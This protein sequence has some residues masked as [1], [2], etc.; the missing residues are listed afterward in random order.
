MPLNGSDG[1]FVREH[2]SDRG[3]LKAVAI[4]TRPGASFGTACRPPSEICLPNSGPRLLGVPSPR[5]GVECPACSR[6]RRNMLKL[7]DLD[8]ARFSVGERERSRTDSRLLGSSVDD[9]TI[10]RL[11]GR[12]L[13]FVRCNAQSA[14]ESGSCSVVARVWGCHFFGSS[15]A[16]KFSQH[17]TL[18]Q[19]A[20]QAR[21][22][23]RGRRLE[24]LR[25]IRGAGSG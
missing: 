24:F 2:P 9:P 7:I 19:I 12:A 13:C 11:G 21:R 5:A 8:Q 14:L 4:R 23:G 17:P 16:K 22:D 10:C 20:R 6:N 15:Q 18:Y 25:C 1:P 3:D